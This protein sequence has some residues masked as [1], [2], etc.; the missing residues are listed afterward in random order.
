M[1]ETF[2]TSCH[3]VCCCGQLQTG[4]HLKLSSTNPLSIEVA[5]LQYLLGMHRYTMPTESEAARKVF[6]GRTFDGNKISA[7][8]AS[9]EDYRQAESGAWP[10]AMGGALPPPPGLTPLCS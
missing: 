1:G 8:Y 2:S 10:Q 9:E 7:T 3:S 4:R 5:E 6:D